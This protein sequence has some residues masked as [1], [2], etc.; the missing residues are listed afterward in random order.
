MNDYEV[1]QIL[2]M[3]SDKSLKIIP[4]Q[5]VEEVIR[6]TM[7]GKEKTYMIMFP[8][9]ERTIV[10][11]KTIKGKLF[12]NRNEI[13]SHMIQNATAAIEKMISSAETLRDETFSNI[14][15]EEIE[16]F[17][18][19]APPE[20]KIEEEI[21]KPAELEVPSMQSNFDDGIIK[22]DLGNGIVGKVKKE[23]IEKV[24]KN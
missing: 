24:G 4:I 8:N 10:D 9:E 5:V 1:G 19:V 2:F 22:V 16:T 23:E 7:V 18:Y 15:K 13:K 17:E 14:T 21:L 20:V 12:R 3:S 11:I 6:T